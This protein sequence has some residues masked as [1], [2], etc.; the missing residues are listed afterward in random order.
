[1]LQTITFESNIATTYY[2]SRKN[3]P[4]PIILPDKHTIIGTHQGNLPLYPVIA[5]AAR[6]TKILPQIKSSSLIS[7]EKLN[8]NNCQVYFSKGNMYVTKINTIVL[9][10]TRNK[11]DSRWEIPVHKIKTT[12]DALLPV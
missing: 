9:K 12:E 5:L 4:L 10:G 7:I 8:D 1:M 11:K 2:T 3:T 6:L